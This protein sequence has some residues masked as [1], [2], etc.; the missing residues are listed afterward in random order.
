MSNKTSSVVLTVNHTPATV[1]GG[2][3]LDKNKTV[4]AVAKVDA[5]SV[6][7]LPYNVFKERMSKG[8][9]LYCDEKYTLGHKCNNK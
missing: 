2:S 5:K 3:V 9:C 4:N 8:L 1:K 7:R 6:K